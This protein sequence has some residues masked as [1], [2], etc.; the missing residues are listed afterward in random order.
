MTATTIPRFWPNGTR[1][2]RTETFRRFA[3]R[4]G[5]KH[6]KTKARQRVSGGP[7]AVREAMSAEDLGQ[8][9]VGG[10]DNLVD[11]VLRGDE[12]GRI[13]QRVVEAGDR[14]VGDTDD[15]ALRHAVG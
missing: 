12:R 3:K 6:P 13:A 9:L 15:H 1:K 4:F 5:Q 2:R 10:G 8:R 7:C 11:V 14:T